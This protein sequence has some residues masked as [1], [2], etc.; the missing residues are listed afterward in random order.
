MH[1][2]AGGLG[3]LTLILLVA[4]VSVLVCKELKRKT[5]FMYSSYALCISVIGFSL[6]KRLTNCMEV[7][8][9]RVVLLLYY[10]YAIF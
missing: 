1:G 7:F 8:G 5:K 2:L 6:S 10:I 4:T 3:A 9:N